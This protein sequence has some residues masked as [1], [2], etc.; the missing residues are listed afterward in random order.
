VTAVRGSV[1]SERM[2]RELCMNDKTWG[3]QSGYKDISL[4]THRGL[5][6]GDTQQYDR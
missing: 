5:W 1:R 3:K 6:L 2:R 4:C